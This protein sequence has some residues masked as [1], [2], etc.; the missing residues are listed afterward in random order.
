MGKNIS[1]IIED[2][3]KFYSHYTLESL[4]NVVYTV[5]DRYG[6]VKAIIVDYFMRGIHSDGLGYGILKYEGGYHGKHW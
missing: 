2:Y 3:Q 1:D 4:A 6:D 5:R